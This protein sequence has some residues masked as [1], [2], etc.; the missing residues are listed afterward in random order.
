MDILLLQKI[1]GLAGQIPL[2]DKFMVICANYLP[3]IFALFLFGLWST[4]LA[5]Q[6]RIAFLAGIS[7]LFA[8]G[9]AQIING[10]FLRTRPYVIYPVN[11]LVERTSDP[12][13][14]SD[15]ATLAFAISI[16]IFYF[17]RKLGWVLLA[18]AFFQ[19]FARV[20]VGAHFP[21]DVFG[22]AL[23]GT[24]VSIVIAQASV[25]PSVK[26][27]LDSIFNWLAK[28]HLTLT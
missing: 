15:H 21:S 17:N 23:L 3:V 1:N 28:W 16:L 6:Q 7:A 8:L 24:L 13:F 4:R 27:W 10:I 20:Y 5:Q 9:I 26:S 18:I 2:A 12:S 25:M 19:A 22:G 11:L 14:P